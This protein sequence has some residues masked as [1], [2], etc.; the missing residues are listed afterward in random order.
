VFL[1]GVYL[2]PGANFSVYESHV[3]ALDQVWGSSEY[4][5]GFVCGDFNMPNVNWSVSGSGLVYTGSI[6]D[7]VRVVGN[8][9]SLLHFVQKNQI[10]NNT[11][12]LLDLIFTNNESTK[13]LQATDILVPCDI[14][15]PALSIS[16]PFPSTLPMLNVKHTYYDFKNAYY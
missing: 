11:G 4:D 10:F 2:P 1:A 8:Q 14:Y 7:K 3:E 13:V 6:T 16:C 9:L 15:H 5:F 12:S